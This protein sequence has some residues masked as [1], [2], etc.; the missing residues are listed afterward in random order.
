[1]PE[2]QT[3]DLLVVGGGINGVGIARDAAGRGLRVALCEMNDLASA[4]SSASSK[5]IHGGLRYLEYYQFRLVR[6]ALAERE[7]LLHNAPHLVRPLQ[8]VLPHV[9]TIRPAWLVRLG[10]FFYDHLGPHP[11]LPNSKALNL[12]QDAAGRPVRGDIRKGFAYYDC[13]VD[14][15]RL[16]VL[17]AMSAAGLGARIMTDTKLVSAQRPD[18]T[19]RAHLLDRRTGTETVVRARVLVNAAGPWVEQVLADIDAG[20]D[21]GGRQERRMILVKGSHIV[22]PRLYE[23]DFA[24]ILQHTDRRV[25]FVIPFEGDHSLIGTT[26]V[27][28]EG[29]PGMVGISP[30]ETRYLCDAVGAYF[31]RPVTPDD[32]RWSFAGVRPLFGDDADDPSAVTRDYV[33]DL[34]MGDGGDAAPLL[35]VFGGKITTYRRLAEKAMAELGRFFPGAGGDWTDAAPL[36]GGDVGGGGFAGLLADLTGEYPGMPPDLLAGLARRHGTLARDI[37]GSATTPGDLGRRFGAGLTEREID[38]LVANEWAATADDILWR[39]TKCGL[40]LD[41]GQRQLVL[42]YL[43]GQRSM[44]K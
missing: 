10:L 12:R 29:D 23:G 4:T 44:A 28:Y 1:M 35:S 21:D 15:A 37:L 22:V 30:D 13:W 7:V 26:D 11:S 36:P 8:F 5:L 25:I 38:Y 18:G 41:D 20:T 31:T 33:L 27:H 42:D 16:V 9:N 40:H 14:D 19:W 24:Y 3:Y 34:N 32:V 2:T 17:N 6:E 43:A 39:R